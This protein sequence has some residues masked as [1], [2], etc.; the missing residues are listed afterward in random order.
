VNYWSF[1]DYLG[2]GAGAHGKITSGQ[3]IVRTQRTREPRRYL[4]TDLSAVNSEPITRKPV[5]AHELPFEFAM[6]AFRLVDGFT[7]SLFVDRTGL[8]I[9][10]LESALAPQIGRGLVERHATGWRATPNG[11]RFLNEILVALLPNPESPRNR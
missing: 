8:P 1:G 2:I 7:D 3:D 6:N 5:P 9:S 11:F 10:T 4:A